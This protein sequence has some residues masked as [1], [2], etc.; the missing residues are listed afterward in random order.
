MEAKAAIWITPDPRPEH[1]AAVSWLNESTPASFYLFKLEAVQIDNSR[2]APLLTRIVGSSPEGRAIGQQKMELAGRDAVLYE[3]WTRFLEYA[4]AGLP[5]FTGLQPV[6]ANYISKT[7]GV[8][9]IYYLFS[10]SKNGVNIELYIDGGNEAKNLAIFQQLA[11]HQEEIEQTY[12]GPLEWDEMENRRACR[13]RTSI[14]TGGYASDETNWPDLFKEMVNRMA[15][16]ERA[17]APHIRA[18]RL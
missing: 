7:T 12:G 11:A 13:I 10:T 16:L 17:T 8:S 2:P 15:R 9:G 3:F 4:K 18:L 1:I 6:R 14:P 5:F